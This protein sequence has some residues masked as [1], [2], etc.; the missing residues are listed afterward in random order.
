V[1]ALLLKSNKKGRQGGREGERKEGKEGGRER[2]RLISVGRNQGSPSFLG[3]NVRVTVTQS[4][5]C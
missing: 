2:G 3:L 4:P 5:P 1:Q